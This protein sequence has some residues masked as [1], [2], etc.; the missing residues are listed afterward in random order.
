LSAALRQVLPISF[1]AG[2]IFFVAFV[3]PVGERLAEIR[4]CE[5]IPQARKKLQR[6][7]SPRQWFPIT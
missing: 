4:R 3:P 1:V 7:G 6:F 2:P 5:E